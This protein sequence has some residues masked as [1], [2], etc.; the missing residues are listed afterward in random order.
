MPFYHLVSRYVQLTFLGGEGTRF[1]QSEGNG[2]QWWVDNLSRQFRL[3][4]CV[5]SNCDHSVIRL[6]VEVARGWGQWEMAGYF[7]EILEF[8]LFYI[9]IAG[10][11]V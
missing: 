3:C 9:C 11:L 6:I 5:A 7:S 2:Y 1:G 4:L 10:C 8:P